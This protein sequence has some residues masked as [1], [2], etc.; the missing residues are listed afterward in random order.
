MEISK[1]RGRGN[2]L[3]KKLGNARMAEDKAL[4]LSVL[5]S[6]CWRTK[7]RVSLPSSHA[8]MNGLG[9]WRGAS[10]QTRGMSARS[11]NPKRVPWKIQCATGARRSSAKSSATP[12]TPFSRFPRSERPERAGK[13]PAEILAGRTLPHWLE[14]L[15]FSLYRGNAEAK[16]EAA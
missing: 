15:G 14:Q 12:S 16:H 8:S 5:F 7:G 4:C 11:T 13:S 1:K 10:M 2:K 3:S 6:D 9:S